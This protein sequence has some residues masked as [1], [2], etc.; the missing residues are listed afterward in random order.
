M[1]AEEGVVRTWP[2]TGWL[3]WLNL[4]LDLDL[5]IAGTIFF[6]IFALELRERNAN[7]KILLKKNSLCGSILQSLLQIF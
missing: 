3:H 6:A 4:F 7:I 1:I 5:Y 2:Q